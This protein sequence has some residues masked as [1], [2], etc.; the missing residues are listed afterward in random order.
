M[1]R[2]GKLEVNSVIM[3]ISQVEKENKVTEK[4]IIKGDAIAFYWIYF[5][6]HLIHVA[7]LKIKTIKGI[8]K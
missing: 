6:H 1:R 5:Y 8:I 2:E 4:G 3:Q 7:F